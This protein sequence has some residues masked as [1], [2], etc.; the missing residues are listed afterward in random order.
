MTCEPGGL[1]IL[2]TVHGYKPAYRVGGPILSVA[3]L[4]EKLVARGHRVVVF[5][6]NA[7]L[8][9][10]LDVPTNEA[11]M[12]DG[13]ETWYFRRREPLK[14]LFPH[15]SYLSKSL[16][17]LY[18]PELRHALQRRIMDFDLVHTHMPFV[19]PMHAGGR[20]AIRKGKPLFVHQRGA[21]DPERL[22]F[23]SVKKRLCIS[24]IERPILR[25]A[26]T[27]IALTEAERDS[28]RALGVTT[29]CQV[30]PNGIEPKDYLQ[31]PT[32]A[33]SSRFGI[34]SDQIVVLFLS[35]LHPLKGADL[36][37]EAFLAI[38]RQF[39]HAV[40]VLAGPDEWGLEA[41]FR[42]SVS[43]VGL[44]NQ[45]V[46]PGMVSG[47][48]KQDLLA[49]ADLFCLPSVGE[50]FSMAVL[51]ALASGA[52]VMLSPGCHFPEVKARGAGWIVERDVNKWAAELACILRDPA[53]LRHAGNAGLRLVLADYTWERVVAKMEDAYREGLSRHRHRL[54]PNELQDRLAPHR[55]QVTASAR[56]GGEIHS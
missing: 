12:V 39:P 29:P 50:G 34:A 44:G 37:L 15:I 9:E 14:T 10:D 11:V 48:L 43:A 56:S 18:S 35:R 42:E 49:R 33:F 1:S 19:Y 31:L 25:R 54:A 2:F 46:F 32:G 17:Y 8:D 36:L 51:E 21:Y 26:T 55:I 13:V 52:P 53:R 38:G 4:S 6:T 45:V 23:R 40:L 5:T 3:A 22:K 16:G 30:I 41:R 20:A 28:Y 27:L 7:N 24:M 47:S